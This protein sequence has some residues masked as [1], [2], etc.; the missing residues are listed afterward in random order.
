SG[1][2]ILDAADQ[3]IRECDDRFR[4]DKRTRPAGGE[5]ADPGV[6]EAV[7]YVGADGDGPVIARLIRPAVDAGTTRY[8][9]CAI[10]ARTNNDLERI[11]VALELAGIPVA[12]P[13]ES[14]RLRHPATM[15]VMSWLRIL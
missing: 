6:A 15:D 3:I 12:T 5:R 7:S 2:L 1:R 10:L 9:D 4:P 13:D 8:G 14:A 11:R